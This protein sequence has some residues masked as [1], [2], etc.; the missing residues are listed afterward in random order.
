MEE[1]EVD[2][3]SAGLGLDRLKQTGT[4][5]SRSPASPAPLAPVFAN[6]AADLPLGVSLSP[7]AIF[8]VLSAIVVFEDLSF[9][10][11][12]YYVKLKQNNGTICGERDIRYFAVKILIAFQLQV[13][14]LLKKFLNNIYRVLHAYEYEYIF[15]LSMTSKY[16][17][18]SLQVFH[19]ICLKNTIKSS[20]TTA[21]GE[22]Q[23]LKM[24]ANYRQ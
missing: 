12:C 21:Q 23:K 22:L 14:C 7:P 10:R 17:E 13:L 8:T 16:I 11:N 18:F 3:N 24:A 20:Q 15:D 4:N 6:F 19:N 5:A 1:N 9:G 2:W